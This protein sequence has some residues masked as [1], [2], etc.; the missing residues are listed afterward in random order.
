MF[1]DQSYF[2]GPLEIAQLGQKAVIDKLNIFIERFE[3]IILE[4]ALG[5]DFSKALID[6]YNPGSDE[7]TE[8]RWLDILDGVAF[9][10]TSGIRKKYNGLKSALAGFIFYEYMSKTHTQV[11]GIGVQ[12]NKG[13]NSV[14]ANPAH[15][16]A[17]AYNTAAKEMETLWEFL[18][19][20]TQDPNV[21]PEYD[22]RQVNNILYWNWDY[23]FSIR[24]NNYMNPIF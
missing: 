16:L 19:A 7:E 5:Y 10:N 3:P 11:T 14:N 20:K 12:K 15:L 17:D 18:Q 1:I 2:T 23:P 9:S 4:A 13:E 21:Y 22:P 6:G 8:Q 24:S